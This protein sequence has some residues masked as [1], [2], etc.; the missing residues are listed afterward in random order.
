MREYLFR[1]NEGGQV[2]LLRDVLL[3]VLKDQVFLSA[4]LE[5]L[6]GPILWLPFFACSLIIYAVV[7]EIV[8]E[9]RIC[10]IQVLLSVMESEIRSLST[11]VATLGEPQSEASGL[12]LV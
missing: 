6:S 3:S 2:I 5:E 7:R 11:R 10:E 12:T 1:G 8:P 9:R 4:F